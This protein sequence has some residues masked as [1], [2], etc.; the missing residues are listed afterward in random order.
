[1]PESTDPPWL[2]KRN[3][4]LKKSGLVGKSKYACCGNI[5]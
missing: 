4:R 2:L 1:M 3:E 5:K